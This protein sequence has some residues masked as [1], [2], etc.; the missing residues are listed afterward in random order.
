VVENKDIPNHILGGR[1]L[2]EVFGIPS[3]FLGDRIEFCGLVVA[4]DSKTG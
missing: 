3:L 2:W 4:L 1:I